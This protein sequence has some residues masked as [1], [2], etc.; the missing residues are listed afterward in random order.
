MKQLNVIGNLCR[1]CQRGQNNAIWFTM[2]VD[3]GRS[4]ETKNPPLF[5]N[6]YGAPAHL[7]QYLKKGL[8]VY[9]SGA[10]NIKLSHYS[11]SNGIEQAAIDIVIYAPMIQLLKS[12]E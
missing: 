8:K 12:A 2:A 1:D 11:D 6:V 9:V 7:E 5:I 3:N 10:F 4:G